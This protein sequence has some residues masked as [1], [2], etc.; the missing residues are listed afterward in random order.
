MGDTAAQHQL[1]RWLAG[2]GFPEADLEV[3]GDL[4]ILRIG[5]SQRARLLSDI[6]LRQ[7]LVAEAKAAGFTRVA[8]ELFGGVAQPG[9]AGDS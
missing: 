4:L 1:L 7:R 5:F 8:L 3:E 6:D 9:R 2:E